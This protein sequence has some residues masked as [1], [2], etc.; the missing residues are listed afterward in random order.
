MI[1]DTNLA[2][3]ILEILANVKGIPSRADYNKVIGLFEGDEETAISYLEYLQNGGF[4][5][6][7]AVKGNMVSIALLK[8]TYYGQTALMENGGLE[9]NKNIVTMRFQE[10]VYQR[11][12]DAIKNARLSGEEKSSL[13]ASLKRLLSLGTGQILS[14]LLD[15]GVDHLLA[16][17]R[18]L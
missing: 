5:H 18:Q 10:D 6:S 12:E 1:P 4:I 11:L 7:G 14:K 3:K 17:L 15:A 16:L 13:L 2:K 8:L 9:G